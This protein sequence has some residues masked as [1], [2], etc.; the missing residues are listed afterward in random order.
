MKVV[1]G[2]NFAAKLQSSLHTPTNAAV[3][4]A[5]DIVQAA[6]VVRLSAEECRVGRSAAAEGLRLPAPQPQ[7]SIAC[8]R[9]S[10]Q[11]A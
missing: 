3:D 4:V 7:P 2:A 10:G 5:A 6:E 11:A 1:L 9:A 8:L